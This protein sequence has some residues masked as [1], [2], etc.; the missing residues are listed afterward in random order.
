MRAGKSP[1]TIR[2]IYPWI[3]KQNFR[4]IFEM[5]IANIH[6]SIQH[7]RKSGLTYSQLERSAL[8]QNSAALDVCALAIFS[9]TP[10]HILLT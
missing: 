9:G 3:Y 8:E 10:F 5:A 1:I 6:C 7:L 2:V 4:L